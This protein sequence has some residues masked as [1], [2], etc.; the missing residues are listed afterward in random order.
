MSEKKLTPGEIRRQ[1]AAAKK[2]AEQAETQPQKP[3]TPTVAEPK[4]QETS[5]PEIAVNSKPLIPE[6]QSLPSENQRYPA[7][8]LLEYTSVTA[9]IFGGDAMIKQA[10]I[11]VLKS[12]TVHNGKYLVLIGGSVGAVE[13][14]YNRGLT[15]SGRTLV[16]DHVF[17]PRVAAQVHDAILGRHRECRATS[18]GILETFTSAAAI[19][20]ADAGVKGAIVDLVELRLSDDLGGKAF[21]IFNGDLHEVEA[22]MRIAREACTSENNW[23]RETIITSLHPEMAKQ[24]ANT[25]YFSK[26]NLDKL[27][28]SE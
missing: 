27:A 26:A 8:A 2:A 4:E 3:D 22:A 1:R 9:G 17:L 6:T 15:A 11:T 21:A 14:A 12:G 18:L 16:E 19:K 24:V 5:T 28:E 13:E 7:I 20:S 10:P 23:L 25:T